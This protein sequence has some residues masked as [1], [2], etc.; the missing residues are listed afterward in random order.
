MDF[1][2][3]AQVAGLVALLGGAAS[4]GFTYY[5]NNEYVAQEEW[6]ADDLL[7]DVRFGNHI[8]DFGKV[9]DNQEQI[10]ENQRNLLEMQ[11]C[12]TKERQCMSTCVQ[13]GITV[14]S[15]CPCELPERCR[16]NRITKPD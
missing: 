1:K 10:A 15:E 11:S 5:M 4:G 14:P 6:V 2:M 3:L 13:L 8:T 9:E 7:D 12:M 16:D